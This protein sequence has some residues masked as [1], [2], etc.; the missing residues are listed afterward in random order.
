MQKN[1]ITTKQRTSKIIHKSLSNKLN[2]LFSKKAL[3]PFKDP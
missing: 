1:P 3:K 2:N